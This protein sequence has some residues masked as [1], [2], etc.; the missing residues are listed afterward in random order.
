MDSLQ[1]LQIRSSENDPDVL[2]AVDCDQFSISNVAGEKDWQEC[3]NGNEPHIVVIH[4]SEQHDPL[5][6]IPWL[7][8]QQ[9]AHYIYIVVLQNDDAKAAEAFDTGADDVFDASMP[10]EGIAARIQSAGRAVRR[11]NDLMKLA[12]TDSLSGL[13]SKRALFDHAEREWSRASRYHIPL[14]CVMLD[15]DYFK[16]INDSYGHAVGDEAIRIV[17]R[18]LTAN[19]RSRDVVARYGGEEFCIILPETTEV[20][21]ALWAERVRRAL[22]ANRSVAG[23]EIGLAA[24]FGV[25]QRLADT[26]SPGELIELADQALLVAKRSGRD[27]VLRFQ[28]LNRSTSLSEPEGPAELFRDIKAKQVMT[29]VIAG[30]NENESVGRAVQYFLRFQIH[31]APVINNDGKL[32]GMIGERDVLSIMLWPSWWSRK[33]KEV[34][35]SNVVCYEEDSSVMSIYDFLS[36]VSLRAVVIAKNGRPTGVISQSGLLRWLTNSLAVGTLAV[37]R[38]EIDDFTPERPESLTDIEVS[39]NQLSVTATQLASVA[40]QLQKQL[41]GEKEGELIPTVVGGATRIQ[42]LTNDLLAF[43]RHQ[44]DPSGYPEGSLAVSRS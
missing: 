17:A 43:T 36:R 5:Q 29:S 3:I 24:S 1:V 16:R 34:M 7:R 44:V 26:T 23:Y 22:R 2:S 39:G 40:T 13:A 4:A 14:S 42:E 10:V 31:S 33:V 35:K 27:R 6:M 37:P 32:V 15:I 30:L 25:C 11:E 12:A 21:A 20:D 19:S 28:D 8:E 18:I 41:D 38:H 9:L